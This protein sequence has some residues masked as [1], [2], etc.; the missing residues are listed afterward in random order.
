MKSW[1]LNSFST[2]CCIVVS[3]FFTSCSEETEQLFHPDPDEGF[4]NKNGETEFKNGFTPQYRVEE[5]LVDE[6]GLPLGDEHEEL[7]SKAVELITGTSTIASSY[8]S[9]RSITGLK[10]LGPDKD[11]RP[12]IRHGRMISKDPKLKIEY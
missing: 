9:T 8:T 10:F 7:L 2:W 12:H 5:Q 3:T 1:H 6:I 11:P 4:V